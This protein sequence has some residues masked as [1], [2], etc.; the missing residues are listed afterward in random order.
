LLGYCQA[1][2][3]RFC[4][5]RIPSHKPGLSGNATAWRFLFTGYASGSG[6]EHR[7]HI[8]STRTQ[9]IEKSHPSAEAFLSKVRQKSGTGSTETKNSQPLIG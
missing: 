2:T 8:L 4:G 6:P 7:G 9:Q 1:D 5:R 3:C